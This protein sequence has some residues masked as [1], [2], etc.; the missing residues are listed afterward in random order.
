[1]RRLAFPYSSEEVCYHTIIA[2]PGPLH[3]SYKNWC[4]VM[5]RDVVLGVVVVCGCCC[6]CCGSC[7]LLP[8]VWSVTLRA[9]VQASGIGGHGVSGVKGVHIFD[10]SLL[11]KILVVLIQYYFLRKIIS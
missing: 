8:D 6:C 10:A 7:K 3:H 5:L 1:M 9:G 11:H 4:C 2:R